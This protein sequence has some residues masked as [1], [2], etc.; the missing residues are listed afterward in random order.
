MEIGKVIIMVLVITGVHHNLLMKAM[1][2]LIKHGNLFLD[3]VQVVL[4]FYRQILNL[5]KIMFVQRGILVKM[6][7]RGNNGNTRGTAVCL[8]P[9]SG[10]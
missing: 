8:A 2:I 6:L 1:A 5:Y 3:G 4:P 10:R 9:F 7:N